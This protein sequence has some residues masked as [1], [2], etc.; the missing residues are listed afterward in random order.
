MSLAL[1]ER[2]HA[3]FAPPRYLAF[4]FS[5]IDLSASGVK[6]VRLSEGIRGLTLAN[7]T[8]TRLQPGAFT[9][10]EIIDRPAVVEALKTAAKATGITSAN[11]ALPESKA[12]LFETT[13]QGSRKV[14]WSVSVEQRLDELVPLPPT[15]TGFDIINVGHGASGGDVP[16]LGIGI[17]KRIVDNTLSVFDEAGIEVCAFEGEIFSMARALL[18]KGDTSTTLIIDVGKTT[19]KL[20]I[21]AE[22]IPRFATTIGIGG[23]AFTLAIQ[24]HFG[25]TEAEARKVKYENGIVP[26]P[27]NEDYLAAMLSTVSA[28]RDEISRRLEYW[29]SR[30]SPTSAHEPV[31]QA[32]LSG[33]NA[34]IRGLPEYL[35]GSLK[36]P[37][38]TGDVF[39][40]FA[41]R[42]AWVPA[43]DYTESLAYATAIGLALRDDAVVTGY[44]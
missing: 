7:Y 3:A 1:R 40:N 18:P 8:E 44:A 14:D 9:D 13:A 4:P 10:G 32:I 5:G 20:A 29:Q 24:K 15:E 11:V 12:Y 35:E 28:I 30:A 21:V 6:A 39:A 38:R 19:T 23:H 27:G 36:I 17:A 34:S 22:R 43:P 41:S 33:G 25:V 16:I 26:A 31:S 2:L 42:D 37:V